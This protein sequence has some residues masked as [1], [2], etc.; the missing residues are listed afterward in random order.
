MKKKFYKAAE[1]LGFE[2]I[3]YESSRYEGCQEYDIYAASQGKDVQFREAIELGATQESKDRLVELF[4]EELIGKKTPVPVIDPAPIIRTATFGAALHSSYFGAHIG[5][6]AIHKGMTGTFV[7]YGVNW[8]YISNI[9]NE[10]TFLL[11]N[12]A[13]LLKPL[14]AMTNEEAITLGRSIGLYNAAILCRDSECIVIVD[15]SYTLVVKFSGIITM[16]KNSNPYWEDIQRLYDDLRSQ[17]YAIPWRKYSVE[18]LIEA[19]VL[20]LDTDG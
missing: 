5:Q 17:G 10:N 18:Q 2:I 11:K 6:H 8:K 15:D 13:L 20:I 14:S 12:C 3:S 4:K 19:G 9:N 16:H 7:L 1:E